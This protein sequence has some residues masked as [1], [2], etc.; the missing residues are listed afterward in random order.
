MTTRTIVVTINK[1]DFDKVFETISKI[2][3]VKAVK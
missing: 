2:P 3:G 1:E